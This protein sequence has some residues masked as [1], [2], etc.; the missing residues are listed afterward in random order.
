MLTLVKEY[1]AFDAQTSTLIVQVT[2]EYRPDNDLQATPEIVGSWPVSVRLPVDG[3]GQVTTDISLIQTLIDQRVEQRVGP[4]IQADT[5]IPVGGVVNAQAIYALTST[6]EVDEIAAGTLYVLLTPDPASETTANVY[7]RSIMQ[8]ITSRTNL[9]RPFDVAL[10]QLVV[11]DNGNIVASLGLID[12]ESVGVVGAQAGP[13]AITAANDNTDTLAV[14]PWVY[15]TS[16]SY[17]DNM[18]PEAWQTGYDFY[19]VYIEHDAI[20]MQGQ[21]T[22]IFSY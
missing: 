2:Q 9:T 5:A 18:D 11:L 6:A 8:L 12:V 7:T 10:S 14:T 3:Q 22:A 16:P 19:Q 20:E 21:T 4:L 1:S 17:V 13:F 15:T